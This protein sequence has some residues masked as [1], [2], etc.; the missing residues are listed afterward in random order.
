MAKHTQE[1]RMAI[2]E[3]KLDIVIEQLKATNDKLDSLLPTFVTKNELSDAIKPLHKEIAALKR[4]NWVLNTLS[5]I[6][7]VTLT[8]LVQMALRGL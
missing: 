6:L 4:R 3:T 2:V 7:G 1:E 5:A 8:V